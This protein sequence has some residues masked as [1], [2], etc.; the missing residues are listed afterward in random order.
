MNYYIKGGKLSFNAYSI[1]P[2]G[3]G[4]LYEKFLQLKS[5]LENMGWFD[6]AIKKPIPAK[7]KRNILV[8]VNR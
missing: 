3:K 6:Q 8:K 4:L 7:V 2:Y 1:M 5:K